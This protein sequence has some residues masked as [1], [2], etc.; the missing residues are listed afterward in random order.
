MVQVNPRRLK[1]E[2]N[3]ATTEIYSLVLLDALHVRSIWCCY[4]YQSFQFQKDGIQNYAVKGMVKKRIDQ[5]IVKVSTGKT[6]LRLEC[7]IF[8]VRIMLNNRSHY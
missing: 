6:L 2:H 8:V 3:S 4:S 7:E 1:K 5:L